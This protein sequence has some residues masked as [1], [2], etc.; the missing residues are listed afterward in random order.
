MARHPTIK[1]DSLLDAAREVFLERGVSATTAEVAARAGVSEGTLFKRFG[2]KSKL[3]ECAMSAETDTAGLVERVAYGAKDKTA[4]AIFD[5][6][7]LAVF[8][9]FERIVPIVL[10]HMAG[11]TSHDKMPIFG[12]GLP[13]P[14]RLLAAVEGLFAALVED[15][16]LARIE[17]PVL[18]RMFVGAIWQYV[19]L[20]Y[21]IRRF[22]NLDAHPMTPKSFLRSHTR[23]LLSG[24]APK[25]P[26]TTKR[27]SR[28]SRTAEPG[29][30]T[31]KAKRKSR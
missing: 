6:L 24:A 4:E 18:A 15:K 19:F 11:A 25:P 28:P 14:L 27:P 17:V 29:A 21:A 9:K 3:F 2:T 10:T 13:P 7:G 8:M 23:L 26:E 22:A 20:D 16:K 1:D 12:E 31:E 5:E 30:P